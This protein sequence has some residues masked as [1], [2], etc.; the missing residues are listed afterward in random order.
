MVIP[1]SWARKTLRRSIAKRRDIRENLFLSIAGLCLPGIIKNVDQFRQIKCRKIVCLENEVRSTL[2]TVSMCEEME[3]MLVCKYVLGEAWSVI[4]FL[5]FYDQV[6]K[7]LARAF[8][9]P[10]AMFH[11]LN[12]VGCGI[13]CTASNTVSGFCTYSLFIWEIVDVLESVVGFITQRNC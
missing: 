8:A 4:P 2:A 1:S 5:G 13:Y 10:F 6:I 9:D 3:D 7:A 11:T 12:I